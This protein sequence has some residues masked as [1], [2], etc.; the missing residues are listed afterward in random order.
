MDPKSQPPKRRDVA[1]SSLNAA[2]DAVNI[3]KDIVGMTPA[4]AAFASVNVILTM[5]R[6]GLL[7]VRPD[8]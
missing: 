3:A 2:I 6:V 5:I 4:K 1:L 8:K 7:L